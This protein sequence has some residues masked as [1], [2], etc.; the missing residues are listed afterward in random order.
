MPANQV[1]AGGGGVERDSRDVAGRYRP[2]LTCSTAVHHGEASMAAV[3]KRRVR[4]CSCTNS[5]AAVVRGLSLPKQRDSQDHPEGLRL[6]PLLRFLTVWEFFLLEQML[7][8][9]QR[10][11]LSSH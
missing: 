1:C 9:L 10:G 5:S 4:G 2:S 7:A 11:R 3:S 6:S 8:F